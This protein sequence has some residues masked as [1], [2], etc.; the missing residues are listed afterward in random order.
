[1]KKEVAKLKLREAQSNLKQAEIV[2]E[3][4]ENGIREIKEDIE[5]LEAIINKKDAWRDRKINEDEY[6]LLTNKVMLMYQMHAFAH[7]RNEGW[8]PD[9]ESSSQPKWGL[10]YGGFVRLYLDNKYTSNNCI[11]GVAVKSREI[12]Q[13]MLEEFGERISEVYNKQY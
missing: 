9:W 8:V 7:A 10:I 4:H 11:F 1:M 12:A 3:M 13:E 5:N 6:V 2:I